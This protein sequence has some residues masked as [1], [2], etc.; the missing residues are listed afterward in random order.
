MKC[1]VFCPFITVAEHP[2]VGVLRD[3]LCPI[4]GHHGLALDARP[5]AHKIKAWLTVVSQLLGVRAAFLLSWRKKGIFKRCMG[6]FQAEEESKIRGL[7]VKAEQ[8][9]REL[10]W[11][12]SG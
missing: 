5:A 8:C 7:E 11:A 12:G 6:V 2:C 4:G 3:C 1:P 10:G 9:E